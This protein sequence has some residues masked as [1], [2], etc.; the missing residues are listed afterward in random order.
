MRFGVLGPLTVWTDAGEPVTVPG[1]KVRALLADLLV[2]GGRAVSVDRLVE[3]VWGSAAPADPAAALHVR[4]SQLRRALAGAEPGARDLV[5]SQAPGYALRTEAVDAVRFT[6]LVAQ[7]EAAA[8]PRATARLLAEALDL[9]RGPALADFADEEFARTA[10]TRW[11]ELRLSAIEA[12]AEARLALGEHQELVGELAEHVDAHP[13]RERL[14]AAHMRALHRAG[15]TGE[16]L[17]SY[18]DL[19]RRLAD[20][21]GLDPGAALTAVHQALL[22]G[23]PAEHAPAPTPT[24]AA[25]N[26]PAP[27]TD[28][29]GRDHTVT[30][31]RDLLAAGRLVTLTGPGGVGKTSLA[32]AA[33][34]ALADAYPDGV[35]LVDLTA[36]NGSTELAELVLAALSIPDA[37]GG[38]TAQDRLV[39]GLRARETLLVVDNCEHVIEQAAD[40]TAALL[41]A[42]PGVAVLATSREPL[43]LRGEAR[44]E[45]PPLD[46]PDTD[47]PA[48]LANSPAVRLFLARAGLTADPVTTSG[49]AEVCRRLDGIPLALELAA[50]RVPTLGVADLAARL[51][52]PHDRFG[53]LGAGPRD[54]PARQRTLAAVIDW[55]WQLLSDAER[56]VLRS[57]S[58]H[59]GGCTLA[60]AE[61]VCGVSEPVLDLLAGLVDRSLVARVDGPRFRLL[62]SVAAFCAARVR[63]AGEETELRRRH[64]RH[65]LAVAEEGAGALR[66]PGQREWLRRLD[67]EAANMRAAL[68]TFERDG[69]AIEALRMAVALT[70]YWFLR[71][72]LAEAHRALDT[73]LAVPGD[74]PADLRAVARAWVAGL[75]IRQGQAGPELAADVPATID[76]PLDRAHAQWFLANAIIEFGDVAATEALLTEALTTFRREGDRWGEAAVLS[77]RAMLAHM[78]HDLTALE[79]DATRAVELFEQLGDDWGILR[80]RDWLIGLG[81]LTGEYEDAIRM[82]EDGLRVAEESGLWAEVAGLRGWLAWLSV[83]AGEHARAVDHAQVARRLAAEQGQ[84]VSEV[85]ATISLGFACRRAGRLDEAATHLDWL[86]ATA[87][88]Q[89]TDDAY[90]PYLSM[91]L[92]ESA[93]LAAR[94]ENPAAGQAALDE[95]YVLCEEHGD[96]RAMG[97][98]LAAQAAVLLARGNPADAA[99]VLGAAITTCGDKPLSA[100]DRAELD[101]LRAEVADAEPDA[102]KLVD[103]GR[104]LTPQE[105][106]AL[107]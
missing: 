87:R 65:Y 76:D 97:F 62:E 10:V 92:V 69:A 3:D 32:L 16:A 49:V 70:W 42:A 45:V 86:L 84:R 93:F 71:G 43:R 66:G 55:S 12:H 77:V 7:A 31:V 98:A 74:A 105:A 18:Q 60:A 15:R 88:S 28:L 27:V 14:R 25:T 58:V 83:Q 82:S 23:D 96:D 39:T 34:R 100:S 26:L 51:R 95:A 75:A 79:D 90:P 2:H 24:R 33:G 30:R 40:L 67:A 9:W 22:A 53:L 29:V 6:T 103:E 13:F 104:G 99:R 21:L 57:L 102:A 52:V 107:A 63:D 19:R 101:R 48:R 78:R 1:K 73:A 72:R 54:A 5:V 41:A 64:A 11:E 4:V 47:D 17:D 81:D 59:V 46:V 89:R 61:Q 94:R 85:F 91:V 56:T 20:E 106:R 80:A 8:E 44:C 38:R 50:T 68:A 37:A 35:W 36:T